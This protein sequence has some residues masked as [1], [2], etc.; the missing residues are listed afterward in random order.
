MSASFNAR[1]ALEATAYRQHRVILLQELKDFQ[2]ILRTYLTIRAALQRYLA[3][4]AG[5]QRHDS[6]NNDTTSLSTSAIEIQDYKQQPVVTKA[7]FCSTTPS[8]ASDDTH[9]PTEVAT[10]TSYTATPPS[11]S[12]DE[13]TKKLNYRRK[14]TLETTTNP[15]ASPANH[16]QPTDTLK[17][18]GAKDQYIP[19]R[20]KQRTQLP[21]HSHEP[22][23]PT[24]L[25]QIKAEE[26]EEAAARAAHTL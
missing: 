5:D 24:P 22:S 25:A 15:P 19:I 8:T 3:E 9:D 2:Q 4:S 18:P 7:L 1:L 16:E 23:T 17:S 13:V 21:P 6:R 10:R 12:L 26:A 20:R 14:S 11:Q